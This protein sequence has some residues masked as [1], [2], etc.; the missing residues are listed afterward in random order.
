[1]TKYLMLS[2]LSHKQR[3]LMH[4]GGKLRKLFFLCI[5]IISSFYFD[6]DLCLD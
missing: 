1:M 3:G 5:T 2:D 4:V 6:A